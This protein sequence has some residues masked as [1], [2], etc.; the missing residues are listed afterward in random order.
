[1]L[2]FAIDDEQATLDEL[3]EA[4]AQ[5]RPEAEILDFRRASDAVAA[6]QQEKR[7]PDVV[8][9][10]IQ[11]PGL[12][13]L[14]LAVR[15]RSEAPQAKIVFVTGYEQYAVEAYRRRVHGY[16]MKPVDPDMVREELDALGL[17]LLAA[18]PEKLLVRC[19]GW[20]DVFWQ[21]EPLIFSRSQTKELF[22]F[23]I[24]REGAACTAGEIITA[25][26]EDAEAV[27]NPKAYL[28]VLIQD[29]RNTLSEIGL[30]DLL[31]RK[32]GQLAI[33]TDMVDCDYYRLKKGDPDAL[34]A[35]HDEYMKQYSWAE[36][37]LG[38]LQFSRPQEV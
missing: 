21:G 25:L 2:I 5:A 34:N 32:H 33:R 3:H 27:K 1:M 10:D 38:M 14:S 9:S 24:D 37:T 15:I 12:D 20:F 16:L 35:W 6:I 11:M 29:L 4:I 36:F 30:S 13:G 7:Q 28:R 18:E 22:A 23:L 31:I 26:W 17:P 8:F 19:F